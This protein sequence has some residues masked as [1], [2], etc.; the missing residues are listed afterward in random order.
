[1][2]AP[3][4]P[5][6]Q[7]ASLI[8]SAPARARAAARDAALDGPVR[9][10]VADLLHTVRRGIEWYGAIAPGT[11]AAAR[12]GA[13]GEGS[14]IAFPTAT[15]YGVAG[16]HLGRDT[17]VGRSCTLTVGYGIGAATPE[18]GLVVG[19]RCVLGARTTITAH[20]SITLG[21]DV[22]FGQGVFVSDAS[23]GY[24][25]PEVPIGLQ[26][27][28]HEPVSIGA[29]SWIGHHAIVL[30]G[31]RIGRNVVVAAGSVVRGE[32]PDH[33]V[34]AGVPARVVRHLEPGV[35]WVGR[36]AGDVRAVR[37]NEAVVSYLT[38]G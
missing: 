35:G 14:C 20:E 11:K 12:F 10:T 28:A 9:R 37:D 34:V 18:R 33:R 3:S 5:T 26:L 31:A 29:G 22:W 17:L 4:L 7:L 36:E 13:F 1:M 27:G 2:R 8:A 23:H 19:D 24:L 38:T 15:L 25:D 30:P 32:V 6:P 16:I 21:D